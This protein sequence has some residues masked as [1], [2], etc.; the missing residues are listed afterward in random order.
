MCS[1]RRRGDHVRSGVS[2]R[3]TAVADGGGGPLTRSCCGDRAP[4]LTRPRFVRRR[5]Y[6]GHHRDADTSKQF[7]HIVRTRFVVFF[8]SDRSGI[9]IIIISFFLHRCC[10]HVIGIRFPDTDAHVT[11]FTCTRCVPTRVYTG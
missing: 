11:F 1:S 9:T 5:P 3:A 8:F 4:L 6:T 2:V 10:R 7:D